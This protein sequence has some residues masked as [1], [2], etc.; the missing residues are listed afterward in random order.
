MFSLK[1]F[2]VQQKELVVQCEQINQLSKEVIETLMSK[3]TS[4]TAQLNARAAPPAVKSTK[5]KKKIRK[6]T[7]PN[8]N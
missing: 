8:T 6:S 5:S 1:E 4:L 3:I 2:A 7:T